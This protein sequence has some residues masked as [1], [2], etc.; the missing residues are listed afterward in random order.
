[1]RGST[2]VGPFDTAGNANP[3]ATKPIAPGECSL[4]SFVRLPGCTTAGS[5]V[6][7]RLVIT[8]INYLLGR[9][10]T[11]AVSVCIQEGHVEESRYVQVCQPSHGQDNWHLCL[12]YA[13]WRITILSQTH[14][15]DMKM[16]QFKCEPPSRK[17]YD[18]DSCTDCRW[19]PCTADSCGMFSDP[20]GDLE[21]IR[22]HN[23]VQTDNHWFMYVIL[24]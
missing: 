15:K 13:S 10:G 21:C 3:G 8:S 4:T 16:A 22:S 2:F 9:G 20:T 19:P 5:T 18:E 23:T 24:H 1:M 17:V 6:Q 7:L 12:M 11:F 14:S